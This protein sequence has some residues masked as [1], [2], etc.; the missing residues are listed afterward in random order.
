VARVDVAAP[1]DVQGAARHPDVARRG[2]SESRGDE[3][4]GRHRGA[5]Q[6]GAIAEERAHP[7]AQAGVEHRH[8]Q[9]QLRVELLRPQRGVEVAQVVL[10]QERQRAGGL[11]PRRGERVIVQLRPLDDP[12]PRQPGYLWAETLVTGPE[13]DRH[14][15]AVSGGQLLDDA[16]GER[17]LPAHDELV[18]AGRD[19]GKGGHGE[20]LTGPARRHHNSRRAPA[21]RITTHRSR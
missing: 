1:R 20:I 15:F 17:V 5:G 9:P 8:H 10:A 11:D 2:L 6:D 19:Q 18:A 3:G 21:R 12:H 4:R 7:L 16:A 14:G 13:H